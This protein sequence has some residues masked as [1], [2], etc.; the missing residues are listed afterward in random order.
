[1]TQRG[2]SGNREIRSGI[3]AMV[4]D[5]WDWNASQFLNF[6]LSRLS[7]H[8][9]HTRIASVMIKQNTDMYVHKHTCMVRMS[10]WVA[11]PRFSFWFP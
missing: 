6:C 11:K 10:Q 4:S 5:H 7:D 2:M 8:V 9:Q 3:V 1:M